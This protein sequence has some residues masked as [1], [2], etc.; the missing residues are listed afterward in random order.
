[1]KVIVIEDSSKVGFGGGQRI[2]EEVIRILAGYSERVFV[3]D[4]TCSSNSLC[5]TVNGVVDYRRYFATGVVKG[6]KSSYNW[7]L[8][9]LVSLPFLFL[10]N[11]FRFI[12]DRE[13][14]DNITKSTCYCTTKK[15]FLH[16]LVFKVFGAHLVFHAHTISPRNSVSRIFNWLVC[17]TA[18]TVIAVSEAIAKEFSCSHKVIIVRNALRTT[19][20]KAKYAEARSLQGQHEMVVGFVGTL[21][22]SKGIEDF[23]EIAK[24]CNQKRMNVHLTVYGSNPLG[25]VIA[26]YV[27]YKGFCSAET[28]YS[29]IDILLSCSKS[30]ESFGLA[31]LEAQQRGIPVVAPNHDAFREVVVEGESG[32]LYEAGDLERCVSLLAQLQDRYMYERMSRGA[33]LSASRFEYGVFKKQILD[34]FGM[35][36]EGRM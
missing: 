30:P 4:S 29:E 34:I 18:N 24:I 13:L 16:G 25:I 17:R 21:L 12:T 23:F 15:A 9:E 20:S 11:F 1:M 6:S 19:E 31:L 27:V 36:A 10:R 22:P 2:T 32:F 14:M 7:T 5:G 28:I 8:W 26:P 35:L 3:L 33:L